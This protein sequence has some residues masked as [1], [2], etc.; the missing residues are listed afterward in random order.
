MIIWIH[1]IQKKMKNEKQNPHRILNHR[2]FCHSNGAGQD[3][4]S[5]EG[6]LCARGDRASYETKAFLNLNPYLRR[7]PALVIG[8][9]SPAPSEETVSGSSYSTSCSSQL[10]KIA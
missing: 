7:R 2:L 10:N 8:A 1:N 3:Q 9:I 6:L 4:Y 5:R